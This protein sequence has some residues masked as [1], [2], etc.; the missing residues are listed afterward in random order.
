M[1]GHHVVYHKE[2]GLYMPHEL[3]IEPQL[4]QHNIFYLLMLLLH[5]CFLIYKVGIVKPCERLKEK[6]TY[7]VP[8]MI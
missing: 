4:L 2:N 5:V 7:L 1:A 3:E 6:H 8:G